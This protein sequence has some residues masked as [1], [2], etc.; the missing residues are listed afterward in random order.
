MKQNPKDY[1]VFTRIR[2]GDNLIR[3]GS[4]KAPTDELAY[5][6]AQRIY[7]EEDW[8][9]MQLIRRENV[10]NVKGIQGIFA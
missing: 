5:I 7:D 10:I 8:A 3:I 9:E 2:R 4:F 6:Y 1:D